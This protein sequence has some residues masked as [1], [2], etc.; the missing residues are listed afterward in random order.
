M[1]AQMQQFDKVTEAMEAALE[2]VFAF[3]DSR[4]KLPKAELDLLKT[5]ED[6]RDIMND[7][8]KKTSSDRQKLADAFGG[9]CTRIGRVQVC[10]D[11]A[12]GELSAMNADDQRL[13]G[14]REACDA[15]EK[16]LDDMGLG[17]KMQEAV[18]EEEVVMER[19]RT[20]VD[21]SAVALAAAEHQAEESAALAAQMAALAMAE[22]EAEA[23]EAA[24]APAPAPVPAPEPKRPVNRLE[25]EWQSKCDE[26]LIER[27]L[28][29]T[30]PEELQ[31]FA[32]EVTAAKAAK[33]GNWMIWMVHR[34]H[35]NDPTLV[36]FEF[37]NLKMPPGDMEPR[38]SPKLALAMEANTS[39]TELNLACSNLQGTEAACLAVSLRSN[40]ALLKLNIDSNALQP[41]EMES[42]ANGVAF[43]QTLQ[44]IRCN[45]VSQGR[46]VYEAIANCVKANT[47]IIKVGLEIKDPHFRGQIDGQI[48]RNN[49][50]AR[51]RRV[52]A[53]KAAEAAAKAAA[54]PP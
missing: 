25:A 16:V 42:I 31:V 19:R 1:E 5:F 14:A 2:R 49:D 40:R 38:I 50:A 28:A 13:K 9:D 45:N 7:M 43:A 12:D 33:I 41:L 8:L 54:A 24:P 22:A 23:A 44:E 47:F 3:K 39:I 4:V 27:I 17:F 30:E 6:A 32:E 26:D 52:E 37:T 21:V 18:K 34:A 36:K 35:L 46:Q 51:K 53:K 48:T 15:I 20:S 11:N 10:L 29:C